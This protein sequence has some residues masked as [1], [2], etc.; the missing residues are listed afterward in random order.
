L[1]VI[2]SGDQPLR[3]VF[4]YTGFINIKKNIHGQAVLG[5]IRGKILKKRFAAFA[6]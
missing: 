6:G 1:R 2:D 3:R 5:Q 4:F